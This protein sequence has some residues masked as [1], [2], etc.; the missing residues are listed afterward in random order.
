MPS[1]RPTPRLFAT[2]ASTALPRTPITRAA[3]SA[4]VPAVVVAGA[5]YGVISYVRSQL[6]RESD[7]INQMF[8]QRDTPEAVEAHRRA[9]L[10]DTEGDP[11]RSIYN[12]LNWK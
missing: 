3:P 11:R 8:A 7:T 12:V 10:V 5:I 6:R 4:V 9:L 1:F 2:A